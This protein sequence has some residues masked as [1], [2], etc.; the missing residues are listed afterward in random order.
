MISKELL[1][2]LYYQENKTQKEIAEKLGVAKC[3]IYRSMKNFGI[4][5][6]NNSEAH[7]LKYRFID[8]DKI[9]ELYRL[10]K[11]IPTIAKELNISCSLVQSTLHTARIPM[12]Q[13]YDESYRKVRGNKHPNWKGGRMKHEGYI[14]INNPGHPYANAKGYVYEHRLVIEKRLG[15][16]LLP[17]EK[18]HHINGIGD[19]NR[20]E[21]LKLISNAD[22]RIY[23]ELCSRCELRK[24]IRLLRWQI[25]EL[26][27]QLQGKLFNNEIGTIL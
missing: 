16:Y 23:T 18:V 26:G 20:E 17:W 25:M 24:E 5:R 6:R 3:T 15:R 2:E 8:R 4:K 13:R 7:L 14:Y 19:D 1:E 12:R 11:G 22:H 9:I 10:G 27:K 21:N